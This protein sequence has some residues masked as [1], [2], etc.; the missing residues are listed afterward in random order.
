MAVCAWGGS[1]CSLRFFPLPRHDGR[2]VRMDSH[3][4]R[5][6]VPE[7]AG[8]ERKCA[9]N[10]QDNY[11]YALNG[12]I[13]YCNRNN[14]GYYSDEAIAKYVAEKYDIHDYYSFHSCDNHY[15]SQ[16]CRICKILKDLNE[17]RIPENRYLAK[18]EC[19]SISEF[20]NAI[21]DF[22][23]YYIGFGY[24]KGCADIYRK[25]AT[26]FLEHCE[27]TGLTNINDIDEMVINQFILTLTQYSKSTIK[28]C[29]GG[30]RAF[31]RYL[32][33]ENCIGKNLGD[34]IIPLKVKSQTRIPSVWQHDEVLKLLSVI[35]RGNPTGKRDYAMLLIVARLGIRIGDLCN[36]KFSN[37]DWSNQRIDFVQGKT[38][39]RIS[40]PLLKDVGWALIDY[41]QNGRPKIDTPYIFVTHVAPF[42]EF[43]QGNRH[44]RMVRKYMNLAHLT[45]VNT[46]KCGMHSLRHTLASTMVENREKFSNISATLGHR[47]EDS[48]A[49]Y[50]KTGV[51]LLRDCALEIPEV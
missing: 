18:T 21:D 30:L 10:N 38:Q 39:H 4:I 44:S 34:S 16:I 50:L 49:I 42:K 33:M 23:K 28:N 11:R 48:T 3:Q 31:F 29:L 25:Y 35:D 45:S 13:D 7:T 19:L 43:D 6:A 47:S 24:S 14:D 51:E 26:L 36:L 37:I 2:T 32:Y 46:H 40:L 22:H 9:K 5:T 20:A 41:I 17:N 8:I 1:L 27:N 15:L 12:M